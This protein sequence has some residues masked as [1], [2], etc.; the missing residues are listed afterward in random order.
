MKDRSSL[1][2]LLDI[3]GDVPRLEEALTHSSF[4]N[5]HAGAKHYEQ[6]EFLGDAVLGLCVTEWLLVQVPDEREG[7]LTRMRAS[8][9]STEALARFAKSIDLVSWVQFGRGAFLSGDAQRENVMADVVEALVAAVYLA[10]GLP[11]ARKLTARIVAQAVIDKARVGQRDAKSELQEYV[12]RDGAPAP[13]YVLV[14]TQGPDHDR[15]F[16]VQVVVN[17]VVIGQGTGTSKKQAEKAAARAALDAM[18]LRK[19]TSA[20]IQE[21]EKSSERA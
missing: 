16:R 1:L 2:E 17:E 13:V 14:G 20:T 12:Q 8:V 15:R 19:H 5:E 18:K 10:H 7:R 6:L 9:V 21:H 3:Q 11:A 4:A